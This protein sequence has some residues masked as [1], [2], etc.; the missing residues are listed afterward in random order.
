MRP[1]VSPPRLIP[2]RQENVPTTHHNSSLLRQ[3]GGGLESKQGQFFNTFLFSHC[4]LHTD[5]ILL[6][7][8]SGTPTLSAPLGHSKTKTQLSVSDLFLKTFTLHTFHSLMRKRTEDSTGYVVQVLR[9][10]WSYIWKSVKG[11]AEWLQPQN[12][13]I[14]AMYLSRFV[15][16]HRDAFCSRSLCQW[17]R[18]VFVLTDSWSLLWISWNW[19]SFLALV[20]IWRLSSMSF[21]AVFKYARNIYFALDFGQWV[22]W[23][24]IWTGQVFV[25]IN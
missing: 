21:A 15:G 13:A 23:N 6:C 1:T 19:I 24:W 3:C 20:L 5:P 4:P 12:S 11:I 10:I 17:W 22:N 18:L 7:W 16:R 8:A 2:S 14:I 25:Y 9:Y